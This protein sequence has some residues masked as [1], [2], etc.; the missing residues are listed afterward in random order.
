MLA[1]FPESQMPLTASYSSLNTQESNHTGLSAIII[2]SK[3]KL[4]QASAPSRFRTSP[5]PHKMRINLKDRPDM[6]RNITL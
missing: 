3:S 4:Y 2:S 5:L 6:Q 1:S